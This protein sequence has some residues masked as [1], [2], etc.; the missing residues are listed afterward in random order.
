MDAG[1]ASAGSADFPT[2]SPFTSIEAMSAIEGIMACVFALLR[3]A[4]D[5]NKNICYKMFTAC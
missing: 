2:E 1:L 3:I 5:K 4:T